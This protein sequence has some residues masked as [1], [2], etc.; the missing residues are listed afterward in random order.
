MSNISV[1]R[2]TVNS[3]KAATAIIQNPSSSSSSTSSVEQNSRSHTS[4]NTQQP[5]TPTP[6]PGTSSFSSQYLAETPFSSSASSTSDHDPSAPTHAQLFPST[7]TYFDLIARVQQL[8]N[9]LKEKDDRLQLLTSSNTQ[10]QHVSP[11]HSSST[12]HVASS[13]SS[14]LDSAL[15]KHKLLNDFKTQ[16]SSPHFNIR[17]SKNDT[18]NIN[19]SDE[20]Y[21]RPVIDVNAELRKERMKNTLYKR[22][23]NISS[24]QTYDS[25]SSSSSSDDEIISCRKCG[26]QVE[27]ENCIL[28]NSCINKKNKKKLLKQQINDLKLKSKSNSSPSPNIIPPLELSSSSNKIKNQY[29]NIDDTVYQAASTAVNNEKYSKQSDIIKN[30][31]DDSVLGAVIGEL[32]NVSQYQTLRLCRAPTQYTASQ[33]EKAVNDTIARLGKFGGD[34]NIAPTWLNSFCTNVYRY[35]FQVHHCITILQQCFIN[36]AKT[37]LDSNL[38]AI[39]HLASSNSEVKPIEALLLKFKRIYMGATQIGI[40]RRR[41]QTSKLTGV[42]VSVKELKKHYEVF[43]NLVN[44]IRLCDISANE[45]YIIQDFVDSL[46]PRVTD[47]IGMAYV[48]C[49]SLDSIYQMAEIALTKHNEYYQSKTDGA[50]KNK[51][52]SL[53]IIEVGDKQYVELNALQAQSSQNNKNKNNNT[54]T[55]NKNTSNSRSPQ[56]CYHCGKNNH[57]TSECTLINSAQTQAGIALWQKR[58]ESKGTDYVYDKNYYIEKQK[59]INARKSSNNSTNNNKRINNSN[60]KSN[61][62]SSN[63]NTNNNSNSTPSSATAKVSFQNN[64][65]DSDD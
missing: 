25:D 64:D 20:K 5:S 34:I 37:W 46:P 26:N 24:P 3:V 60:N 29:K 59:E 22:N 32:F 7:Q 42:N 63:N 40:F 30:D 48:N 65:S 56:I 28:C 27:Q 19:D 14:L 49:K 58:N 61:I 47:F 45:E 13:S 51:L 31:E 11:H 33:L 10:Q 54:N 39:S 1:K 43:V 23:N 21:D 35:K 53:N 57:Y 15:S 8:E 55:N 16:L 17:Y 44:N 18:P 2:N 62:K 38:P 6:S 4:S 36:E 12:T 50:M 52:E 41:L 9:K